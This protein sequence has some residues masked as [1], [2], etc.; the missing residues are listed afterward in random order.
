M[1]DGVE[2]GLQIRARLELVEC[3]VGT[4]HSLLNQVRGVV[5]VARHSHGAGVQRVQQWQGVA[6]KPFGP[7]LRSL[8]GDVDLSHVERRR[9]FE[10]CEQAGVKLMLVPAEL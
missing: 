9:V 4:L 10:M 6:L 2:P 8:G 3:L 7:L 1:E 5:W